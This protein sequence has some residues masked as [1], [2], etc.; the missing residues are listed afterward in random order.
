MVVATTKEQLEGQPAFDRASYEPA[1]AP[2]QPPISGMPADQS[3]AQAPL[4]AA[5][6]DPGSATSETAEAPAATDDSGS[7]TSETAE[8]PAATDDSGSVTSET[9]RLLPRRR[10]GSVTSETAEAPAAADDSG[11]TTT[12]TVQVPAA[13]ADSGQSSTDTAQVPADPGAAATDMT[14]TA[15]IDKSTLTEM[16]MDGVRAE[17]LIGTTVYGANDEKIG[18]IGDIVLTA[19]GNIDAYIIDVGGFLGI[20]EKEVALGS[21]NLAFMTD[22]DG[23]SIS[24]RTSRRSSSRRHD[25]TTS[26]AGPRSVTKQ[27]LIITR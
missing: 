24:T 11:Q 7:A 25:T 5:P 23:N 20:G 14:T 9:A 13:P 21:D 6:A 22:N 17:E 12:E 19:D 16:P 3:T 15:A 4:P 8:A 2:S 18:E 26:R 10:S 27:R 1:Q